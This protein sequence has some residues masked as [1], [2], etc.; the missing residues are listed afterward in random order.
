MLYKFMHRV[1][2]ASISHWEKRLTTATTQ[3]F[4]LVQENTRLLGFQKLEK[5][6]AAQ[7]SRNEELIDPYWTFNKW[8]KQ[9]TTVRVCLK[10]QLQTVL[11]MTKS[12]GLH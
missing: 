9:K 7:M 8:E 12:L 5:S 6:D 3:L 11:W 4:L 1:P 10:T 2:K